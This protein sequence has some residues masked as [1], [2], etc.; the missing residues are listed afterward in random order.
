MENDR[1]DNTKQT[2]SLPQSRHYYALELLRSH[3]PD[4]APDC[5]T[6]SIRVFPARMRADL[7]IAMNTLMEEG[8]KR[9]VGIHGGESYETVKF[10]DLL[11]RER[12]PKQIGPLQ[13]EEIDIG[14]DQPVRCLHNGLWLMER[15]GCRY[16]VWMTR[17]RDYMGSTGVHIEIAVPS[18][19]KGVDLTQRYFALLE[20]AVNTSASYRG[21]VLSLEQLQRYTGMSTG[22]AVH[23]LRPVSREQIILPKKTI[24][25]LEHNIIQFARQRPK[26]R[27]LHMS[28]KKGVLFYG[29]PG[30]GKT[31]TIHF[32][33]QHLPSHTTLLVTA[34]QMGLLSEYFTLARL[35]QPSVLVI[36]DVDL[37]A[38]DRT[39]MNSPCEE[40][41]LNK[42]L[43]EMDGLK[44]DAE[45]FFVLTTNRPETL[46]A[47]LASRPGRI[48]QAIEFPLPDDD[49]R[50][51]LIRLYAHKMALSDSVLDTIARKTEGVSGAFIKELMRRAAQFHLEDS[52]TATFGSEY[53]D[54]ALKEMVFQ[55]GQLNLK[56]LGGKF[57]TDQ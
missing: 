9:L 23:K 11:V 34:E 29:P 33:A 14:E 27:E 52:A 13:F 44:E 30:T 2:G 43:N 38:R 49:G 37:I 16:A 1:A 4:I 3:M 10:A 56:L 50:K 57:E 19:Q 12:T 17:H 55:G 31:H 26:L 32:L 20:K 36:E 7:Q 40:S 47:A 48:D 41:L 45:I 15:E 46:E 54:A 39:T 8:Q 18:G 53:I 35:L 21:K 42:L 22:I 28:T 6:T 24:N 25:L 51:A 5:F